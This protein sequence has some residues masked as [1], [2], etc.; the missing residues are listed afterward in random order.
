VA[1]NKY[2]AVNKCGEPLG[3]PVRQPLIT[4]LESKTLKQRYLYR[5]LF[6]TPSGFAGRLE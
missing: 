1:R 2:T 5:A 4:F 3:E 6:L